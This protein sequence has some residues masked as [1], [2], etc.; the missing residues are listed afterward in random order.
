MTPDKVRVAHEMYA[1]RQ[2]TV[3]AIAKTLGV[4]RS[5]IYR[6]PPAAVATQATGAKDTKE[7]T[8]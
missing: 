6:H 2:Y 3:A 7:R 1:S 5:S 8:R 4:S